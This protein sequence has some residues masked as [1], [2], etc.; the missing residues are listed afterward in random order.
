MA[1]CEH[2]G[3]SFVPVRTGHRFCSQVC[4][5]GQAALREPRGDWYAG[6]V[7]S[8]GDTGAIAELVVATDLM[9]CG[10]EV[11]RAIS[12]HATCDLIAQRGGRMLRVEVRTAHIGGDGLMVGGVHDKAGVADVFALVS[13]AGVVAYTPAVIE[14]RESTEDLISGRSI[15]RARRLT[16]V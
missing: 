1:E 11:F 4:R 3:R 5:N 9:R 14:G 16:S 15:D 7:L 8:P 6:A 12:P 10:Y 13:R 2:C